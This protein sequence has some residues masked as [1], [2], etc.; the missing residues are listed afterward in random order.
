MD[1]RFFAF[2]ARGPLLLGNAECDCGSLGCKKCR[3]RKKRKKGL[4]VPDTSN[5]PQSQWDL[6]GERLIPFHWSRTMGQ[7]SPA[8][9]AS[10]TPPAGTAP[11]YGGGGIHL[12]SVAIGFGAASAIAAGVYFLVLKKKR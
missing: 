7:A 2:E 11:R 8:P 9:A 6:R 3:G 10:S 12:E 1:G 4:T 5:A